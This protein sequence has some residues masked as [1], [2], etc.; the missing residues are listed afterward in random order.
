MPFLLALDWLIVFAWAV[1]V[2]G[3]LRHIPRIPNL[4]DDRY[5]EPLPPRETPLISVIVPAC[6]EEL[7]IEAALRSLLG[8]ESVPIEV[9]V[10]DDRSTDRTGAIIDRLAAEFHT[11]LIVIRITDLPA[12]WLGK[13][14]AM[15]LAARQASTPWLLFTDADVF[16]A[17]DALLRVVNFAQAERADHVVL[18]PTL[19]LQNFG[20]YMMTAI[21]Q[22]FTFLG[23]SPWRVPDPAAREFVGIGAFNMVRADAY[24]AVGGF[25]SLRMEVIEDLKLGREIK[26]AGFRQRPAFGR[27]LVRVRWAEGTLHF[28]RNVTKNFFAV[29]RFRTFPALAACALLAVMSLGPFV[30]LA[31]G[32]VFGIPA[33][34]LLLQFFFLYRLFQRYNEVPTAYFLTF[35]FAAGLL[36]YAELRS[37]FVTLLHRGIYWR[38]TFYPLAELRKNAGPLR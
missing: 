11:R 6:N 17:P 12:G 10:V 31:G 8:I 14:H 28:I 26:R 22:V 34:L 13:P 9:I 36:I 19:I 23:A 24:R 16:F 20:E 30:A 35:P 33:A 7:S 3:A 2:I 27:R 38:G 25:E 1:R 32:A 15:A 4:L 18:F 29:F 21:F 37:L 5:A